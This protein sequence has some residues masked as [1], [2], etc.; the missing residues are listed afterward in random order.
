MT[1][2][3]A[4]ETIANMTTEVRNFLRSEFRQ[5]TEE[6]RELRDTLER[7]KL[8][9]TLEDENQFV[10]WLNEGVPTKELS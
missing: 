6:N 1:L 9:N 10:T 2:E 4:I 5:L 3:E 7:I 8:A